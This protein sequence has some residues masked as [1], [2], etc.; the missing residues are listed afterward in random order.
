VDRVWGI[1]ANISAGSPHTTDTPV[2]GLL[3]LLSGRGAPVS[4]SPLMCLLNKSSA[5]LGLVSGTMWPVGVGGQQH[6]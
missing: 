5:A 3:L 4:D 6:R 1:G 2:P